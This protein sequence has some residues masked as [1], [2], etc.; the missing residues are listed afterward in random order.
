MSRAKLMLATCLGDGDEFDELVPDECFCAE[1]HIAPSTARRWRQNSEGPEYL[2]IG[3]QHFLLPVANFAV[4][5][6]HGRSAAA[7]TKS[8]PPDPNPP[9]GVHAASWN[10]SGGCHAETPSISAQPRSTASGFSV[11]MSLWPSNSKGQSQSTA[12][13]RPPQIAAARS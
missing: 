2:R 7:L 1:N 4:G 12:P 11:E 6:P 3:A 9:R 10:R 5:V 13:C 8:P